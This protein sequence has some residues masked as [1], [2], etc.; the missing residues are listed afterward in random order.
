[1]ALN[2]EAPASSR[3]ATSEFVDAEDYLIDS[4]K[5]GTGVRYSRRLHSDILIPF[6]GVLVAV[7]G[8]LLLLLAG[9]NVRAS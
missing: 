6:V 9:E 4:E 7:V 5:A 2:G 8:L 3:S 1:M